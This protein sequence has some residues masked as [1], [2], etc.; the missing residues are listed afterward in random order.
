[1]DTGRP[2]EGMPGPIVG[3]S[4]GEEG[5]AERCCGTGGIWATVF[6]LY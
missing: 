6:I 2:V 4:S 3:P 1:M 5:R